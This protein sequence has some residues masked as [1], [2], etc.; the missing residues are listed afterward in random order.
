MAQAN[1][2][3][4]IRMS[5]EDVDPGIGAFSEDILKIEIYGPDV[6]HMRLRLYFRRAKNLYSKITSQS[7]MCP[8]SSVCPPQ[9]R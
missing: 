5:T 9:V 6:R 7:L 2:A 8:A 1:Q 4:G 3:M